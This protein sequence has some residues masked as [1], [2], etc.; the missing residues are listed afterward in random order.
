LWYNLPYRKGVITINYDIGISEIVCTERY[1]DTD[2]LSILYDAEI[3]KRPTRCT[4][5]ACGHSIKPH[6]HS[7]NTNVI[8]DIK[9]EGKIVVI[10]L[11]IHRYRCP[12]CKYVFPDEFTFYEKD[13]HLTKRLKDE[14]VRRCINGETY[15]YIA[16]DY[17][18][19]GKTVA[20]AFNEYAD[21]HR[22]EAVL[23]YTPIILGI[24]EAHI[25]DHYRLVLT[26]IL[27]QKLIDIKKSN[28]VPT[29]MAYLKTLDKNICKCVTM[30]F[31]KGYAYSVKKV[32][33]DAIIVIDKYHVIQDI[34][35]CVDKVRI[36]LQN[37]YRSQGY[38]IRVFKHSKK[39][40][41][42]N[43]EDLKPDAVEK[44]NKW[45][46]MFPE[47][48]EA[49]MVK[50]TFRDIYATAKTHS[51]ALVMFDNWLKDIPDYEQF[52]AM[53][54]TFR[55]RRDHITNYWHYHWTNAFTESTNNSIK[56]IEKAGRGYKFD[57]LR[58][59]CILSINAPAP[60]KFNYKKAVY[61]KRGEEAMYRKKLEFYRKLRAQMEELAKSDLGLP[62][63]SPD[64][65]VA[66]EVN[67]KLPNYA[68]LRRN[69]FSIDP[70]FKG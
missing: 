51:E 4:N 36:T 22:D 23:T 45:F 34:N 44:L 30:D 29:V 61:L 32:L 58:D 56:K 33:P 16:N 17:S 6:I 15:R 13:E 37:K 9:A 55:E 1:D 65:P 28:K 8:K 39:L 10:R 3:V 50:E 63:N 49:Y 25:D 70:K 48:Y 62:E 19:D 20:K 53:R 64:N 52:S 46:Q 2:G 31:A 54:D 5:P 41:M 60:D 68:A 7:S 26:D 24:D 38:D 35:S 42:T 14:F 21:T 67:D 57:V 66:I 11:K 40:F 18:V 12:D 69:Y 47:L 43:W 59:R 27:N